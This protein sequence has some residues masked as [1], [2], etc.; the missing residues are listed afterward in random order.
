MLYTA[1]R[2]GYTPEQNGYLFAFVGSVSIVGQGFLFGRLAKKFGE[3]PL[4]VVGCL[5]MGASLFAVPLVGPASGGL[6]GLLV[7]TA[8]LSFGNSLASPGLTSLASKTAD[9][10]NQGRTMGIMQSGASLARAVG[11]IIGGFLLNNTLNAIDD[12]SLYRTFWTASAIMFVA[13]LVAV[14]FARSAR[15]EILA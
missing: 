13:F 6:M 12:L 7:G 2:F 11:P 3:S 14:Y 10:Q 5:L 8:V 4:V 15:K 1:Y 9:E